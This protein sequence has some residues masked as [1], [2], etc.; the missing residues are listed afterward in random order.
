MTKRYRQGRPD[1]VKQGLKPDSILPT[2]E[3]YDRA[4]FDL[5]L[6]QKGCVGIRAYYAMNEKEQVHLVFVGVDEKGRDMLKPEEGETSDVVAKGGFEPV[7]LDGGA[8]C[9]EAC[10]EPSP[11]NS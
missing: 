7:I 5:L 8:R 3:T 2:C 6:A 1:V 9:P 4:G 10:P 11:L